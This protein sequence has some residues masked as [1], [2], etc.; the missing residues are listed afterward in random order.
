MPLLAAPTVVGWWYLSHSHVGH[1]S[2]LRSVLSVEQVLKPPGGGS[3]VFLSDTEPAEPAPTRRRNTNHLQSSVLGGSNNGDSAKNKPGNDSHERLFGVPEV[4]L[5]SAAINRFKSNV[6]IGSPTDVPD[7]TING[8]KTPQA[9]MARN[10]VT[11]AGMVDRDS[12]LRRSAKK[13]GNATRLVCKDGNPVTG[14][15]YVATNGEKA[16]AEPAVNNPVV[17]GT[18][19]SK[20]AS[21]QPQ[22]PVQQQRARVPPGGFSSGL[23]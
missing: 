18:T 11:G 23:W 10:P 22:A 4:R 19:A 3:S 17:N 16:P 20:P 8:N 2:S 5:P 6:P 15:G 12:L 1:I 21:A 7:N 14:E 13:R 9:H